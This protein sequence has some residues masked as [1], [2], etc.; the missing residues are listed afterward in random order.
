[1]K[2]LPGWRP[3]RRTT[4]DR[5]RDMPRQLRQD[6]DRALTLADDTARRTAVEQI[7][8]DTTAGTHGR[9]CQQWAENTARRATTDRRR[10]LICR[11]LPNGTKERGAQVIGQRPDIRRTCRAP[12][13][14][15]PSSPS[16]AG[17]AARLRFRVPHD[18]HHLSDT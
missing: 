13:S 16:T 12:A 18:V 3:W 7:V 14:H 2:G 1:M 9:A 15:G 10:G 17:N 6:L 8:Q 11:A 5:E 4:A